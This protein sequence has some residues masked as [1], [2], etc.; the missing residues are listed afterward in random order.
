MLVDEE[1]GLRHVEHALIK[2]A[3]T[4]MD[5]NGA[6]S[7]IVKAAAENEQA[8]GFHKKYGFSKSG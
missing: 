8:F 5:K 4:W 6:E 2:R 7:K 1:Y 3:L